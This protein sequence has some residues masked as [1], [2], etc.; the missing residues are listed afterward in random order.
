MNLD[1][2]S[3]NYRNYQ[4][5]IPLSPHINSLVV[6]EVIILYGASQCVVPIYIPEAISAPQ[7]ESPQLM[8]QREDRQLPYT[9]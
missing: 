9:D 5:K 8:S 1:N 6:L 7:F 4:H 3:S 2:A